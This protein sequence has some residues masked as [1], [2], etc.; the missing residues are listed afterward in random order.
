M[1]LDPY[2]GSWNLEELG[3]RDREAISGSERCNRE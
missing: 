2:G 1:E 3:M